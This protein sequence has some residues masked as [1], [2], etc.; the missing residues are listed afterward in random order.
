MDDIDGRLRDADPSDIRRADPLSSR[1][2]AELQ[3]Y[4]AA[5]RSRVRTHATARATRPHRG[6]RMPLAAGL[7]A[8]TLVVIAALAVTFLRPDAA[9]AS[10]PP[11]LSF[12][13]VHG[14]VGEIL[15]NL[16]MAR[17]NGPDAGSSIRLQS[18]DLNTSIAADGSIEYSEIEPQWTDTTFAADGSVRVTRI[19]ADPFPGQDAKGL[20]QA[21][22]V[23]SDETFPNEE[24]AFPA[25]SGPPTDPAKVAAYLADFSGNPSL[26]TGDAL[27]EIA[28]IISNYLLSSDQEAALIG[29]LRTL[30][31]LTV[32]GETTDRLG[33]AG[34]ALRAIDR[35]PGEFEDVLIISPSSGQILASETIYVGPQR[36]ET[37]SPA[38]ISYTAWER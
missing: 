12:K 31:A 5:E 34:I 13:P 21:G 26:T 7:A 24:W 15:E 11:L 30:P 33:R 22:T 16:R 2:L 37:T 8:A 38:V 32:A 28:G 9:M 4:E 23:L 14:A 1:A 18:W 25:E 29:Y 36:P 19:A 20:P 17:L 3:H 10:T 27:R 6:R 35:A